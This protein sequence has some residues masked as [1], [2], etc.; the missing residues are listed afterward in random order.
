MDH[1]DDREQLV[2]SDHEMDSPIPEEE[3]SVSL[4]YVDC[5]AIN[6]VLLSC[7]KALQMANMQYVCRFSRDGGCVSNLR[8]KRQGSA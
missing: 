1:D 5:R 3:E 4:K 7:A 6:D 8:R 2:E